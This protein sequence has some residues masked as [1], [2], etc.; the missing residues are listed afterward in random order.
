MAVPNESSEDV[1]DFLQRIRELGERRD[2][3]DD[4]RTK[5]LEE[6][7]LQGRKERQARRAARLPLAPGL[8]T[9]PEHLEPTPHTESDTPSGV[10]L[11]QNT[12][13]VAETRRGSIQEPGMDAQPR[14]LPTLSRSRAGTL[15]WQQRPPSREFGSM[16]PGSASPTRSPTRA[17]HLRHHSTASDD[18][19]RSQYG[20]PRLSKDFSSFS[21][22]PERG[23]ASTHRENE[24]R[25]ENQA[26]AEAPQAPEVTEESSA[27]LDKLEA[28][29]E[30]PSSP[31]RT[32]SRDSNF[33]HRFSVSSVS[34]GLGS[35]VHLSEAQKLEPRQAE[36]SVDEPASSPSQRRLSPER[37]R[38]TSPTKGMGGFVQSAM[39]RRSDSVSKRWSA[40]I[41]QGLTRSNSIISNRSSVAGP[42]QSEMGPP[43]L[44]RPRG[45]SSTLPPRPDSSHSDARTETTERPTTPS[46]PTISD[47][48]SL[49]GGGSPSRSFRPSHSRSASSAT[50]DGND[51][52]SSPF[53]SKTMDPRRW[54]PSKATWLESA[55][56]RPELPRQPT[57][58]AAQ[59]PNWARDRQS[60]GSV[61]MGRANNFKEVTPVGLMRTP[62]PGLLKKSGVSG[63]S[64]PTSPDKE[65]PPESPLGFPL[66]KV[67]IS[68][69]STS[70]SP[71]AKA[72]ETL[73][74]SPLASPLK[75]PSISGPSFLGSP[76]AK[77]TE[78]V[79]ESPAEYPFNKKSSISGASLSRGSIADSP[80]EFPL[81]RPSISGA[82]VSGSP[83]T[84]PKDTT[85]ASPSGSSFKH[86]VSGA[87]AIG[88]PQGTPKEVAPESPLALGDSNQGPT[89]ERPASQSHIEDTLKAL[90]G[91]EA[92]EEPSFTS[93][94]ETEIQSPQS[95]GPETP[96]KPE[97]TTEPE[98]TPT[99]R[100]PPKSLVSP[101]PN[102]SISTS[103]RGQI[104]PKP[105]PA[106]SPIIDFRAN[107]KKREV[108]KEAGKEK[109][110]DFRANL[111]KREV[112]KDNEQE[113]EPEFKNVFGRLKKAETRNYVA[114]DE[115]KGNILRGKAALNETGGPKK[116]ERVD[117]FRKSLVM[118]KDEMKAGGGSIR[119][120]TAGEKDAP[121][122]AEVVPEAI[123]MRQNMTRTN[124]IKQDIVAEPLSPAKSV[125]S[126]ASVDRKPVSSTS[127]FKDVGS[128]RTSQE[129]EPLSPFPVDDGID[130]PSWPLKS[131][132]ASAP[133]VL[134]DQPASPSPVALAISDHQDTPELNIASQDEPRELVAPV[135]PI[136]EK[137]QSPPVAKSL[138]L[139]E[140][141]QAPAAE[142]TA[143]P[144]QAAKNKL[145]GRINPALAGL[146]SRGPPAPEGPKKELPI[147]SA[148]SS[149]VPSAPLEHATKSR[150]RGP[151]RRP[152]QTA[153]SA[154]FA[155]D[156]TKEVG[157]ISCSDA[158][159]S[160]TPPS[161]VESAEDNS[162]RFSQY[163]DSVPDT[164]PPRPESPVAEHLPIEDSPAEQPPVEQLP[165]QQPSVEH[166]FIEDTLPEQPSSHELPTASS[167]V[168]PSHDERPASEIPPAKE[169]IAEKLPTEE[170]SSENLPSEKLIAERPSSVNSH[171]EETVAEELP[172]REPSPEL[173]PSATFVDEEHHGDYFFSHD[174]DVE[175]YPAE[176]ISSEHPHSEKYV[177]ERASSEIFRTEETI[178]EQLP[179]RQPSFD[180]FPSEKSIDRQSSSEDLHS[181]HDFANSSFDEQH[182]PEALSTEQP[183]VEHSSMRRSYSEE[184]S[185]EEPSVE[186]P[187]AEKPLVKTTLEHAHVE[188]PYVE[189]PYVE[190]P[191][192]ESLHVEQPL[193]ETLP[194]E[195]VHVEEHHIEE[196]SVPRPSTARSTEQ[197]PAETF[198]ND[199]RSVESLP[200]EETIAEQVLAREPS[201]EPV[202]VE[203]KPIEQPP[204]ET[205]LKERRSVESS[206]VGETIAEQVPV[207]ALSPEPVAVEQKPIEQPS[208]EQTTEEA[209]PP[210]PLKSEPP[211]SK[212]P[213]PLQTRS[214]I[215]DFNNFPS[216]PSE[217][218]ARGSVSPAEQSPLSGPPVPSKSN[219]PS[220]LSPSTPKSRWA[221]QNR[222]ASPSPSPL[223]TSYN[224]NRKDSVATLHSTSSASVT[225]TREAL[226]RPVGHPS[227]P[228][229]P[230][231]DDATLQK[232]VDPRRLSRK[233]SAPSLVAQASEARE[234]ISGFFKT[235][236]NPQNRMDI[237]PQMLLMGK[238]DDTKIRTVKRHIWELT[239]DGRR[240]EL[241]SHQEYIL[242]QG[243]MY[244]CVH[245]FE[246][247]R[248]TTSEV[249]LWRG[250]DVPDTAVDSEQP[251]ARKVAREN[252][253]K[254][255]VILQGKEPTRFIQA[256]GGI[257]ITRRGSSSRHNSSALY[258][259][260]GRKHLGQMT[261][262]EVDYSLRN[263]CSGFPYVVSAPFGKLY[264]WKGR[265]SGPEET[266]AAR[267]IG[268]DLGLTGEFEE[269]AEGE[270]PEDFFDVFAGPRE[271]A[272]HM[273]QDYWS[274]KSKYSHFRTRLL[275]VDHEL[276]QPTR[277]WNL[278]RPGSGSPV[279]KPNDCVQEIE[280]FCYRD[281]GEKDVY[282][283]DTFFEIYVIVGEQ[284]IQKSADFASAVVFAH[285]Y[286]ILATSL[287]DRPFIP[288]S[289]VALGGVADRCQS[290]F[291]KWNPR[292]HHAPFVFPLDVVIES[293]RSLGDE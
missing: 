226:S 69:A 228:V 105:K 11:R 109:E 71:D 114:P 100:D 37:S 239:G 250:D 17:S 87:S 232:P 240:Q 282:V 90:S 23:L 259:L 273:C 213:L 276:G 287:Q 222:Y 138:P 111:R 89:E 123:A 133:S 58:P 47:R 219:S 34:A 277:F 12:E 180:F 51:S 178:S 68:G 161:S 128:S 293:L 135:K 210:V 152:P 59:Q 169:A 227:P 72:K 185:F 271:A 275:R 112:V 139:R 246:V 67:S 281:I 28:V 63:P 55:L 197:P 32:G 168:E 263:L 122:A 211:H 149:P 265:G 286:G 174:S 82:S 79:P 26:E 192:V 124:S 231:D 118:R 176:A 4:E 191:S 205:L 86:S 50:G 266:G 39:M 230:K 20:F 207:K 134:Q 193:A 83:T 173:L 96:A 142:A 151:K 158:L 101:K 146:L 179:V 9:P 49:R 131:T 45:D 165:V 258:M 94:D 251:F 121:K 254:L 13:S 29:E 283:L 61:D 40:Q 292:N 108:V 188:E 244:I 279:V 75:R 268:M 215:T 284:A 62:P 98:T 116:T 182:F 130:E 42:S 247:G 1:N 170:T 233:M 115:L 175:E 141:P 162:D 252:S 64:L 144:V 7:I 48:D 195:Q 194:M 189:E 36:S 290:A 91:G 234:V 2:K 164:K 238:P 136:T 289:Y 202:A 264:L 110:T 249:Y 143:S 253:S 145:A 18:R 280:P 157:A 288:K 92:V 16:S 237:D 196:Q 167:P 107:L 187:E 57:M 129:Q 73:P 186:V 5:K 70:G 183:A 218:T 52:Q 84:H 15:S 236:P 113:K 156:L 223:R 31:P 270:E 245:V 154:T 147:T 225:S 14:E 261:F 171:A 127:S 74:G 104:S 88:S 177:T 119:R 198:F 25:S 103:S 99:P 224:E 3:E 199:R 184:P 212:Y 35:P 106:P 200:V 10:D 54:S 43:P 22:S 217:G 46:G 160:Q 163:D 242:Y 201:P 66:K 155:Q 97:A 33:G 41:P 166:S 204:A 53:V 206:P 19:P 243:S 278:R 24:D 229:P 65:N 153:A 221:Q 209:A 6:E 208:I 190:E 203:Q 148:Q 117:E 44:S 95:Q 214:L 241:P 85:P 260:C 269:V 56:N 8:L 132:E 150:A 235:F 21:R 78:P 125:G 272:P 120:N 60:R 267:L 172:A 126:R 159:P 102:F 220:T 257:M 27:K 262:D 30:R 38:S 93:H 291:R 76:E 77:P 255:Q 181:E 248:S 140:L 256:L 285:E 274:L 81:K 80:S 216:R 137:E